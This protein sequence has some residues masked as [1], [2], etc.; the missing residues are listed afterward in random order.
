MVD[1]CCTA[2]ESGWREESFGESTINFA[3][4]SCLAGA[5]EYLS[6]LDL[7]EVSRWNRRINSNLWEA[8]KDLGGELRPESSSDSHIM[9]VSFPSKQSSAIVRELASQRIFAAERQG[10][11]R[12]APHFLSLIHI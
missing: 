2:G 7:G 4:A 6:D 1:Q 12:W 8:F 3:S 5:L 9:S 10:Y 11:I